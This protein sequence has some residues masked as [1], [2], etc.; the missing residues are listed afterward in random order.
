V[1][2]DPHARAAWHCGLRRLTDIFV[3]CLEENVRDRLR[4]HDRAGAFRS[5]RMLASER[6][7]RWNTLRTELG[8]APEGLAEG[9]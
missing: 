6:P 4:V 1:K 9:S 7:D 3:D 8:W 5:A 2:Q